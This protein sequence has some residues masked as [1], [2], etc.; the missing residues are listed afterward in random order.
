MGPK[1]N[2][3]INIRADALREFMQSHQLEYN[4]SDFYFESYEYTCGYRGFTY[5]ASQLEENKKLPD[6]VVCAS[7]NIAVRVPDRR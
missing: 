4:E 1:S 5:L 6:A 7:D 2:Y 3:E